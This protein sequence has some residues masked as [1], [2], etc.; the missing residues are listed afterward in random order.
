MICKNCSSEFDGKFCPECGAPAE[1]IEQVAEPVVEAAQ[2]VAEEPVAE[3]IV[4]EEPAAEEIDDNVVEEN[5]TPPEAEVEGEYYEPA[6]GD[7]DV[8]DVPKKKKKT[9]LIVAIIIIVLAV[10][11]FCVAA[12]TD[13]FFT[14][15]AQ[16]VS[17]LNNMGSDVQADFDELESDNAEMKL[18]AKLNGDS[19]VIAEVVP[20]EVVDL[21]NSLGLSARASL[22][23]E[24]RADV[25]FSL[26]EGD[27]K[28]TDIFGL[29]TKDGTYVKADFSDVVF[30]SPNEMEKIDFDV[31]A[32]VEFVK[33]ELKEILK[34]NEPV[35]GE[36]KGNFDLGADVKTL[37]VTL[38]AEEIEATLKKLVDEAARMTGAS[39]LGD[40]LIFGELSDGVKEVSISS[41]YTGAFSFARKSLGV[42]VKFKIDDNNSLEFIFY[43]NKENKAIYGI[44]LYIEGVTG[45][46]Y[47]EDNFEIKNGEQ[48]GVINVKTSGTLSNE[49]IL[50]TMSMPTITYTV[51]KN[52]FNC[53]IR[54]ADGGDVAELKISAVR[55]SKG[56]GTSMVLDMNSEEVG[57]IYLDI[58]P[59]DTVNVEIDTSKAINILKDELTDDEYEQ[60]MSVVDDLQTLIAENE[61]S[62]LL[63]LLG[64]ALGGSQGDEDQDDDWYPIET[65]MWDEYGIEHYASVFSTSNRAAYVAEVNGMYDV[66][67]FGY[68]GDTIKQMTET[69]YID[70]Y[71]YTD[72][73]QQSVL[74]S[75]EDSFAHVADIED[76]YI[77]C[78]LYDDY[79][80]TTIM[81]EN[82]DDPQKLKTFISAGLIS[83]SE[84]NP[85][86][87]SFAQSAQMLANGGYERVE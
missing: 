15:E 84:P 3:E 40:E 70:V 76:A 19:D 22:K 78:E 30:V 58:V 45:G 60:V 17:I 85:A 36:Y 29:V 18:S 42:A 83:S 52:N 56:L 34:N 62:V 86:K 73:Q 14:K 75:M 13:I 66:Q 27:E 7:G 4:A 28:L 1:E 44:D 38:T 50:G 9:G 41:L 23:S 72:A 39:D 35:K 74:K 49:N 21:V 77:Y 11:A 51:K 33:N 54:L 16:F 8:I 80:I 61:D 2:A 12:F 53:N 57:G 32:Y 64:E 48:S 69:L 81:M 67:E 26:F 59:C 6:R 43:S 24:E 63:A 37:T 47:F 5:V 20:E 46:I 79:V 71:G 68:D 87:I 25:I 31:E 10:A 65:Y 55:D 82:L